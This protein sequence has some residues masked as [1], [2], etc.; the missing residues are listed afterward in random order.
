MADIIHNKQLELID[1]EVKN[2][3][4]HPGG[5]VQGTASVFNNT[6][7]QGEIVKAGAFAQ[8][9]KDFNAGKIQIPLLDNHR[10]FAGT[11]A[12]VGKVTSLEETSRG[13]RFKGFFSSVAN[14]Q[15]IRIKLKEKVLSKLSIGFNIV[16]KKIRADG[17][18]ELLTLKLR[19]ISFVIFPANER[20]AVTGVKKADDGK[21]ADTS[22]P[23]VDPMDQVSFADQV[24]ER[25]AA[26][27]KQRAERARD[28]YDNVYEKF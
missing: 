7:L 27:S 13:L 16:T 23:R 20:A 4:E 3:D 9:V 22:P 24:A 26:R 19:E 2:D 25:A 17:I 14:A 6:D 5:T 1:I 15:A 18:V 21:A 28:E 10:I 8:T 12:L 11:E